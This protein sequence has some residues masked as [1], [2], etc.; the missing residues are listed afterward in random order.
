MLFILFYILIQKYNLYFLILYI[1][2]KKVLRDN[3]FWHS[4]KKYLLKTY[5][6]LMSFFLEY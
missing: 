1:S 5:K 2:A 3:V 6:Y 4:N